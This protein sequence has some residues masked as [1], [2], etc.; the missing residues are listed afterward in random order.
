MQDRQTILI[1]THNPGKVIE[2]AQLMSELPV[3]AISLDE[4]G[5]TTDVEETGATFEENARLKALAYAR[6][7]GLLT[8]ADDSGLEVDAL[9]GAPGVLSARYSGPGASDHDRYNL[10]LKNLENVPPERRTARFHCVIA[11][12]TPEGQVIVGEGSVEGIIA[13]TPR[14]D[15]GFGYDPVFYIP[16]YGATMAELRSNFKNVISH[17]AHAFK[18]IYPSLEAAIAARR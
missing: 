9:G 14:G 18:A 2:Y 15:F 13:E 8:L 12:A 1:A 5:I 3:Q 6:E 10:L 17:R 11:L 7:S 16:A 4:A